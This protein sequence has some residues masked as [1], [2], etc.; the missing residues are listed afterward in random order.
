MNEKSGEVKMKLV[1][2][3]LFFVTMTFVSCA[4]AQND[5]DV[6]IMDYPHGENRIHVMR[7]GESYLYFG[8]SPS[9]KTISK[10]TF[11]AEDLYETFKPYLH[12]NKPREEWP[13]RNSQSGMITVKFLNG[14]EKSF[15]IFDLNE[16]TS[17]IFE[18]AEKNVT[19][20]WF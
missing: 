11:S 9:A 2:L 6:F 15:L 12:D 16:L 18:R 13:D 8:A 7:S 20:Q 19:G 10:D 3:K 1:T 17:A 14:E 5:I 4:M